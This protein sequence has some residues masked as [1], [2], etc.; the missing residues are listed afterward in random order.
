MSDHKRVRHYAEAPSLFDESETRS[1]VV[2]KD[3]PWWKSILR[4]IANV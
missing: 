2:P 1:S 4:R 3:L